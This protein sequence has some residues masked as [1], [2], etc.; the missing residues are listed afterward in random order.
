MWMWPH[1]GELAM[2]VA[3]G[4]T[5]A[6]AWVP[7]QLRAPCRARGYRTRAKAA[8]PRVLPARP[9]AATAGPAARISRV[10]GPGGSAGALTS[11]E[12]ATGPGEQRCGHGRE[13]PGPG[14]AALEFRRAAAGLGPRPSGCRGGAG[15][16]SRTRPP[17]P[18]K[19]TPANP[20]STK[21][22]SA[23]SCPHL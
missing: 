19:L 20:E 11:A 6:G 18:R 8:Q 15:A 9:P 22:V 10:T 16:E 7:A 4:E 13:P 1:K 17:G 14:A 3:R 21:S 5:R 12:W 23:L 2:S